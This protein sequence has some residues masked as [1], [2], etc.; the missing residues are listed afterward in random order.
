MTRASRTAAVAAVAAACLAIAPAAGDAHARSSKIVETIWHVTSASGSQV[1]TM[2]G[3]DPGNGLDSFQASITAHWRTTT[4]RNST[5]TF[6][7]P[8]Q[9]V[10]PHFPD[11]GNFASLNKPKV[12][13][14]GSSSGIV[15]IGNTPTPFSCKEQTGKNPETYLPVDTVPITGGMLSGGRL[16]IAAVVRPDPRVLFE[17]CNGPG[18][19][20]GT[21][22]LS[23]EEIDLDHAVY[24]PV[25][26]ARMKHGHKGEKMS[27]AVKIVEPIVSSTGAQVGK[28]VSKAVLHL[29]FG[30]AV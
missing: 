13:L 29:T 28:V 20:T 8:V 16:G 21:A 11:P 22:I 5:L 24:N 19:Q 23:G 12:E 7:W 17:T 27:L 4:K 30:M 15:E 3:S 2:S 26:V 10:R 25:G 9:K 14:I 18:G 1:L 6:G